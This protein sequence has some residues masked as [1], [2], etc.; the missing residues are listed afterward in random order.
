MRIEAV[1]QVVVLGH[2]T[3]LHGQGL[4]KAIVQR[5]RD[6]SEEVA[7]ALRF[8]RADTFNRLILNAPIVC[9]YLG[10]DQTGDLAQ[11]AW[12][13]ER[14]VAVI[15]VVSALERFTAETPWPLHDVNGTEVEWAAPDFG[16][17]VNLVLEN[18]SLL[19]RE[20]RLFISYFRKES[21]AV[22]HQLRVAFDDGGYDTFFDLSSVPKG[23]DFQAVI[24]HRLLDSDVM[25]VLDTPNFLTSRW[26]REEVAQASAMSVGILRVAW[27][28]VAAA[29]FAELASQ[30]LL[31]PGDFTVAE[32]LADGALSRIVA[33]TEALR[34]RNVAARHDNL[35]G[36]F[37]EAAEA[38]GA[39]YAVQPERFV[40]G[41]KA[42]GTRVAAIPAVGVPDAHR[43]HDAAHRFPVAGDV[44]DE[45]VLLYDHRGMHSA[46]SEFLE[47]LDRYLPVKSLR[48]TS[49]ASFLKGSQ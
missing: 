15:P 49:T 32:T 4:E 8:H 21:Q 1:Y 33:A 43:F 13:R 35:V 14:A 41:W 27:P 40:L 16:A 48:V 45:A 24:W 10:G 2:G 7:G 3:E 9:V 17:V 38:I 31:E 12:L 30:V 42:D 22:A 5:A 26:T 18:L 47:W 44:A 25:V 20:R 36:E 39:R 46:W 19:R 37:C 34:A 23:D 28:G 11:I 29:R 6:I